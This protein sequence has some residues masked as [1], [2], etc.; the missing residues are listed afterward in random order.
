MGIF[1]SLTNAFSAQPA[2]DAAQA[3]IS[4]LQKGYAD[5][6]G[7]LGQGREAIQTNYAAGLSPFLQQYAASVPGQTQYGNAVGANGPQGYADALKNFQTQPG[8]Q[9]A[10]DQGSQNVMRNQAKTGQLASGGTNID[11]QNLGQ[12]MADQEYQKYVQNLLPFLQQ[13][14]QAAGGVLQGYSGQG[15]ALAGLYGTQANAAYGT[16]AGI[17][18][19]NARADLAEY[20]ASR[21]LWGAIGSGLQLGA[22]AFGA[23]GLPSGIGTAAS[24]LAGRGQQG[25]GG[26][27][28]L[29]NWSDE[30]LKDDIEQIG[31]LFDGSPLYRFR[32]LW[33]DPE[34][35]RIGLMAQDVEQTNPD[36]VHEIGGLK[37]VDYGKATDLAAELARFI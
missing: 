12:G 7:L 6:S 36:A 27:L 1:D 5:A 3:Q 15:N 14:N 11:L 24:T 19:A 29:P 8:Y 4:G 17:G 18:N 32:Y 20:D 34:M 33:D 9:F 23:S 2:R 31:E 30:R 10:L 26:T 37:A 28:G 16:Q 35:T 25:I 21:N 22:S 13:G